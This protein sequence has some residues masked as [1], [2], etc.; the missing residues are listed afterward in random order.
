MELSSFS[1]FREPQLCKF[2]RAPS[3]SL[4]L[5][6]AP[7]LCSEIN[8]SKTTELLF[9]PPKSGIVQYSETNNPGK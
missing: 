4:K 6:G 9:Y 8:T 1:R 5:N 2:Q 3:F 7:K